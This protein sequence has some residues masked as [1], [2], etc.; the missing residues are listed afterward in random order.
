VIQALISFGLSILVARHL[1]VD[2]FGVYAI[3]T[4]AG[5]FIT[6]LLDGGFITLLQRES[7]RASLGITLEG[8]ILS[9]Y[10]LGYTLLV[11]AVLMLMIIINP[12]SQHVTTLVAIVFAFSPVVLIGQSMSVLRGRGRLARDA[13]LQVATRF[14]TAFCVAVFIFYNLDSPASVLFAQGIGGYLIY[15]ILA[16][17]SKIKPLFFIPWKVFR[18][19]LPLVAWALSVALYSRSDL[20][21]CRILDISR[22]DVGGYAIACRLMEALQVFAGPVGILIFR[23]FRITELSKEASIGK[24]LKVTYAAL[25]TGLIICLGAFLFAPTVIPWVFG[26]QY[27]ASV[28]LFEVLTVGLIFFLG[29]TV[30]FQAFIALELQRSLMVFTTLAGIFNV[31][32]NTM[33]LPIYG[34]EACAWTS[35]LTQCLLTL[36]LRFYLLRPVNI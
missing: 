17:R 13:F 34:I 12:F 9:R 1:G 4:S 6:I 36:S 7:A 15:F 5:F 31:M 21:L 33:M 24:I 30:L 18:V 35:V 3:A 8:Q 23:K 22:S 2:Q 16:F 10:A 32:L 29:N 26:E 20:L 19:T 27:R 25:F 28:V 11:L 14:V